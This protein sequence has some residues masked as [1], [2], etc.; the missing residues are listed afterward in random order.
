MQILQKLQLLLPD[1]ILPAYLDKVFFDSVAF[2]ILKFPIFF[3]KFLN[4][5]LDLPFRIPFHKCNT[6]MLLALKH[7]EL[8]LV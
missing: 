3:N 4:G 7:L 8:Q 6:L 2:K 5:Y 1:Q